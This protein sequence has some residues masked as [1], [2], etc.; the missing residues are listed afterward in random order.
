MLILVLKNLGVKVKSFQR[1]KYLSKVQIPENSTYRNESFVLC[2]F[3]P[4]DSF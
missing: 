2:Y 1:D 3:P 4:K